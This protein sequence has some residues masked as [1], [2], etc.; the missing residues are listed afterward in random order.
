MF[1][2]LTRLRPR[3][4]ITLATSSISGLAKSS[5]Q[6]GS[7]VQMANGT[8]IEVFEFYRVVQW[9][10]YKSK[11]VVIAQFSLDRDKPEWQA[12]CHEYMS[13]DKNQ[14]QE[15]FDDCNYIHPTEV[16][17]REILSVD[18]EG[19]VLYA[20]GSHGW[21]YSYLVGSLHVKTD[22]KGKKTQEI[23][24]PYKQVYGLNHKPR[25]KINNAGNPV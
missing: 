17:E 18:E 1:I 3:K 13:D 11:R 2:E 8:G 24:G 22:S 19:C 25:I 15:L 20:D 23:K 9:L 6:R 10:M 12:W 5:T 4:K 21:I 7:I 14:W 16:E